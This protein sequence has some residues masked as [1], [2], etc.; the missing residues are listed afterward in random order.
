MELEFIDEE[1][2]AYGGLAILKQMMTKSGFID[3]L[4][5]LP[6]P[7]QKSN[8]G[9]SPIQLFVQFMAGVW[10][11]ANRFSQLDV[12]R[13]DRSIQRMFGWDKM[14]EHKA[15]QRYFG[16]FDMSSTYSVFS[17][18]YRWFFDNLKFDNFT[19]DIDSSVITRYGEQEGAKKGYNKHKPGRKSQHP[20]IAFVSEIEMVANFWLRSGDAIRLIISRHF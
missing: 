19:L 13:M 15:F 20:I 11:G 7:V 5:H 10:C 2:T 1:I 17:N 14:P 6:L 18:L 9:Y 8:R 12:T 4:E 3:K 16:K